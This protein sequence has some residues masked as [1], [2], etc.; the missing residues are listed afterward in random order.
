MPFRHANRQISGFIPVRR[1]AASIFLVCIP[2]TSNAGKMSFQEGVDYATPQ[3]PHAVAAGDFDRDGIPDI[4]TA[5]SDASS[6]SVF[7]FRFDTT[8]RDRRDFAVS[9]SS[10]YGVAV[11]DVNKDGKLDI[12]VSSCCWHVSVLLG[13]G[14][15]NFQAARDYSTG[16]FTYPSALATADMNRDGNL[17]IVTSNITNSTSILLGNGDGSFNPFVKYAVGNDGNTTDDVALADLNHNGK[18]EVITAIGRDNSISILPGKWDGTLRATLEVDT[19]D[20][21]AA[22][23]SGDINHDGDVDLVVGAHEGMSI[24]LGS[25]NL[26]FFS[27]TDYRGLYLRGVALSDLDFDG[28]LDVVAANYGFGDSVLVYRGIGDGTVESA[29]SISGPA[30]P[31]GPYELVIV[32]LNRDIEPDVVSVQENYIRV[33]L[34]NTPRQ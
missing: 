30:R 15:G 1:L 6:V 16:D 32:D 7:R 14:I 21:P 20:F 8:L 2:M 33:L 18:P 19:T 9:G 23:A 29:V 26:Q 28:H 4:V 22:L 13:K 31:F 11:A 3:S 12:L 27:R 17:D 24:L 34:N 5:N 10:L 25:G